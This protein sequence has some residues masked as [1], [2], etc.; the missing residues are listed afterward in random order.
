MP[1][2]GH[3]HVLDGSRLPICQ[4]YR[5][6]LITIANTSKLAAIRTRFFWTTARRASARCTRLGSCGLANTWMLTTFRTWIG[7]ERFTVPLWVAEMVIGLHKVVDSEIVFAVIE[8]S[9]TSDDLFEFN[10]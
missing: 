6:L 8:T 4:L 7:F 1:K 3:H 9:A 5:C 2:A 10:H